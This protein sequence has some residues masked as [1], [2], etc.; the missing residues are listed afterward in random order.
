M[1]AGHHFVPDGMAYRLLGQNMVALRAAGLVSERV[2]RHKFYVGYSRLEMNYRLL[3]FGIPIEYMP[4][5]DT[6]TIK[7]KFWNGWLKSR[8]L[9]ESEK[10]KNQALGIVECP[11]TK[12][13]LFRHGQSYKKLNGNDTLREWIESELVNRKSPSLLSHQP[14]SYSKTSIDQFGDRLIDEIEKK[15]KGRFLKWDNN[16]NAWVR[17]LDK[18][19]IKKKISASF[20][21]YSKR[22]FEP[23][24][25]GLNMA[26]DDGSY[27]FIDGGK[28]TTDTCCGCDTR[29]LVDTNRIAPTKKA[30]GE[31]FV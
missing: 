3:S 7:V 14:E 19:E 25:Q 22:N 26:T 13:V 9:I 16:L 6:G 11:G 4:S 27:K 20:Y 15:Q 1:A 12:D 30:K 18:I 29:L 5:T 24:A 28:P 31:D 10:T 23:M 2:V 17:M 8:L 21:N